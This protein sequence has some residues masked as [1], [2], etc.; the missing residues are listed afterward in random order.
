MRGGD[1]AVCRIGNLME[2]D[3][4]GGDGGRRIIWRQGELI[5]V[6]GTDPLDEELEEDEDEEGRMKAWSDGWQ[7]RGERLKFESRDMIGWC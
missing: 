3:T 5:L 7:Q 1:E 6:R 4:G 2:S